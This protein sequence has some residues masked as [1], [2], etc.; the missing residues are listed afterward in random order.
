MINRAVDVLVF[1]AALW[2]V[3]FVVQ[4]LRSRPW[5][6]TAG[7]LILAFMGALAALMITGVLFRL[8]G[9]GPVWPWVR[10][11]AWIVVNIIMAGAWVAV[12]VVQREVRP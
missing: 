4:Y 7:R 6:T 1:T 10:L 8:I 11:V 12:L 9:D 5:R 3:L 2:G